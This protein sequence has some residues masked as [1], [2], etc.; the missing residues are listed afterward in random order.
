MEKTGKHFKLPPGY[1]RDKIIG[2]GFGSGLFGDANPQNIR[3]QF[4]AQLAPLISER[5]WHPSQKITRHGKDGEIVLQ[6]LVSLDFELENWIRGWG[7]GATVLEP[8][9]LREAVAR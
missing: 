7:R 9:S 2:T 4:N 6:L 8:D 3:I 1:D 5:I